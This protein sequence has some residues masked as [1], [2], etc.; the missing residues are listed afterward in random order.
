VFEERAGR[1]PEVSVVLIFHNRITWTQE[2]AWSVLRQ[3]YPD[4]ELILVDDG[5]TE[6]VAPLRLDDPRVRYVRQDHAGAPAARNRGVDSARG[7]YV[8]LL[9]SDDLFL[10]TKLET[11]LRFMQK[12]AD[13]PLT[14]TSCYRMGADG[15]MIGEISSGE[16]SGMVYPAIL[17]EC[18]I[19]TSTVMVRREALSLVPKFDERLSTAYDELVWSELAKHAEIG[20]I[21]E[22]LTRVRMHAGVA[23]FDLDIQLQA[24]KNILA[25]I[26]SD[27]ALK[28]VARRFVVSETCAAMAQFSWLQRRRGRCLAYVAR[29]IVA[30]PL[31]WKLY[32]FLFSS[33]L[34][35]IRSGKQ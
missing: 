8:A 25:H 12:H 24:K 34:R 9:D 26:R 21:T 1:P 23:T 2:A 11:Q 29:A 32:G 16:F 17:L 20:G 19:H 7:K 18:P 3:T 6:D 28:G 15:R 30:W 13:L 33:A 5:S 31:N 27:P 22:P 10:P 14:H 35:Y 4:F